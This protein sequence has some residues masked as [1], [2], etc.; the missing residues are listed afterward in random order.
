MILLA[1]LSKFPYDYRGNNT[2]VVLEN[3]VHNIKKW[4]KIAGFFKKKFLKKRQ[5]LLIKNSFLFRVKILIKLFTSLKNK[6]LCQIFR[7]LRFIERLLKKRVIRY[8]VIYDS[9]SR[10][11]I[12]SKK[13]SSFLRGPR[14]PIILVTFPLWTVIEIA[15][16]M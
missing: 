16:I 8:K 13:S 2:F 10:G 11:E 5:T 3:S 1:L 12:M 7:A 15:W 4:F 6:L 9:S 14:V